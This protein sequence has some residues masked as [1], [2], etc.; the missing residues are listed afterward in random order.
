ML[1][2]MKIRAI[3][4]VVVGLLFSAILVLFNR[5]PEVTFN[6][7]GGT[8]YVKYEKAEIVRVL[9]ESLEK[10]AT[11][12]GLYRG[13]QDLEVKLLSGE[14]KGEVH[15]VK[16]YLSTLYNVHG[17]A[18]LKIIA[19]VDTAGPNT[20][21]V[22]VYSYYR[23]PLLG[24]MIFILL[25][26]LCA[27]GGKKG[28]KSAVGLV[29]TFACLIYLFI[30][31]LYRG[32]SPIVASIVIVM[33]T[34]CVTMFLLDGWSSKSLSAILGTMLGVVIAGIISSTAGLLAH[35]TGFNTNE[36]ESLIVIANETGMQVRGLLF[37]GILIASL[38]AIMDVGISIASS[39]HEVYE[40]NPTL[41][42]RE[43]FIS[44]INVGRDMMG[45]MVNTLILAFT[46]ASLTSLILIYA[47]NVPFNQLINMDFVAIEVIQGVS[48]SIGVILTVPIVAYISSRIMPKFKK[49]ETRDETGD[50]SL[51][52]L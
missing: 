49:D 33:L 8:S 41:S 39:V 15:K 20:Y 35:V 27:I 51:A 1:K 43:L 47:Y 31:M 26:A 24:A 9:S 12:S 44:G 16:N 48:G 29:F 13:T 40:A 32:Y 14:H 50:G 23:A 10:D 18:G 2:S 37:A 38:G 3:L 19:T 7:Q 34:T 42:K 22:S 11:V 25:A 36:S 45:T 17:K 5:S 52:S 6:E 21:Q 4:I 30:P 28:L 46:G